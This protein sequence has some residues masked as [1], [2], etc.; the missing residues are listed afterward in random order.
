MQKTLQSNYQ[1]MTEQLEQTEL[2]LKEQSLHHCNQSLMRIAP[3]LDYEVHEEE[4]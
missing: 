3:V 4:M 2:A 1:K